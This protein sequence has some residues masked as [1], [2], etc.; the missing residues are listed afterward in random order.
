METEV[1]CGELRFP[2]RLWEWLQKILSSDQYFAAWNFPQY[3]FSCGQLEAKLGRKE[4]FEAP[5]SFG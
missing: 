1:A 5:S 2:N 4:I 3:E